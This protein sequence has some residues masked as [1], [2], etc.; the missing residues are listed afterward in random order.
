[1]NNLQ[2]LGNVIKKINLANLIDELEKQQEIAYKL[3]YMND[4]N[5]EEM[6]QKELVQ[7]AKQSC[8]R[9]L[10][11]HLDG[12][13]TNIPGAVFEDWIRHLHPDNADYDDGR[14]DHRFYVEDSDHRHMW[15]E[16]MEKID[17]IERIVDSRHILPAYNHKPAA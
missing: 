7:E 1:M 16:E 9:L 11:E 8:T 17:C 15:N 14:I 10:A 12:F 4:E 5:M 2:K 3:E 13:L 6:K